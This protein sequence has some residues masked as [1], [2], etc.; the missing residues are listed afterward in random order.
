[1]KKSH[2]LFYIFAILILLASALFLYIRF[3]QTPPE[4]TV[5]EFLSILQKNN[6]YVNYLN[7]D[8]RDHPFISFFKQESIRDFRI[9]NTEAIGDDKVR[10]WVSMK[11]NEGDV[12]FYFDTAKESK[13]WYIERLPEVEVFTH[14]IPIGNS[15][16]SRGMM[17]W[18][19]DIGDRIVEILASSSTS[20][21]EMGKPV[22]FRTLDGILIDL[23]PLNPVVLTKVMSLTNKILEDMNLGYFDIE[24]SFPVFQDENDHF[25]FVGDFSIPIGATTV[26]LYRTDDNIGR[27]AVFTKDYP[28][29]DKIRVILQNSDFNNL[30]HP[31]LKITCS[32]NFSVKSLVNGID[33]HFNS[34]DIIQFK[35]SGN[36]VRIYKN[37]E[38]LATS[39]FRWYIIPDGEDQLRV[40][41]II[42]SYTNTSTGTPYRGNLE[43]SIYEDQLTL[44][45]EVN[46][47]EYLYSVVPSEMPVKFGLEALKVQ[48]IAARSYAARAMQT[49]GYRIYGAHVD[50]STASQVYNNTPEN[51][52]AIY[53][54]NNTTG[55]VPYFLEDI[56]D[57]R[58]FSTSYGYTANFHEVW[59]NKENEF[60]PSKVPYLV[61]QPQYAGNAP[62]LY[63]EENFRAFI[64]QKELPGYD[65]FSS[66]FRWDVSM[67]REQLESSLNKNL[68][69]LYKQQPLFV[70]T[71]GSEGNYESA[72]IPEDVGELQNIAVIKRGEGGNIME[73][74]IITT[75]GVFKIIKEY[76]V[77]QV[78]RPV[79][80]LS[81]YKQMELN[82]HDG[83]TRKDFPL[84][85]SAFAC[86]DFERDIEGN[87]HDIIITGGGYGHG[88]GMSQY[89]TYGLTL[90]GKTYDQII[91]HYY[92]GSQLV[93]IYDFQP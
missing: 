24:G 29:Y 69:A 67:T 93:N 9:T 82:L 6:D 70:L 59:S 26:T 86:I 48:A 84:L 83:T 81:G 5:K 63:N 4:K 87:I 66:F 88:V 92:P 85:P 20:D 56:V 64:D 13:H 30:L 45:N 71:R 52:V 65:K 28:L 74:D 43:V 58:F 51:E 46:L 1:M 38:L 91:E 41:N 42:R 35:P 77:R 47:E 14:G 76:N 60:P 3:V 61:A 53:A 11:F 31:E 44:I 80:Y 78:L 34:G 40:L 23:K 55:M 79:N 68:S 90:L 57:A 37:S 17:K 12:R 22:F 2:L 18:A 49:S 50:D 54:V 19:I 89:G 62:S 21:I 15:D 7:P 75:Y 33:L 16:S 39:A 27:M 8:L 10:V 36:E 72:E 32:Y 25:K 73:L